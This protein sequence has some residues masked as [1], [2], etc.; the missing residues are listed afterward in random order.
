MLDCTCSSL[1][2]QDVEAEATMGTVQPATA[3][4]QPSVHSFATPTGSIKAPNPLPPS[5][6]P[7]SPS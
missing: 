1:A 2:M 4:T 6:P 5:S 3:A 7:R